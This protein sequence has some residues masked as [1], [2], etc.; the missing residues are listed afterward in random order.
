[1]DKESQDK[2]IQA[3]YEAAIQKKMK[4]DVLENRQ[5][6][7]RIEELEGALRTIS[8]ANTMP[9]WARMLAKDLL[10]GPV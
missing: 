5:L 6:L 9:V 7:R 2:H 8:E 10:S 1:M 3:T 4:N